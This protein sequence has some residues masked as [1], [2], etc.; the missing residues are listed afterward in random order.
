M[1]LQKASLIASIK[2]KT[3]SEALSLCRSDSR[4]EAACFNSIASLKTI[5]EVVLGVSETKRLLAERADLVT[6]SQMIAFLDGLSQGFAFRLS[7]CVE[8]D[9]EESLKEEQSFLP[10]HEAINRGQKVVPL[11]VEGLL[12]ERDQTEILIVT[13]AVQ[14]I[15]LHME[16]N[17]WDFPNNEILYFAF[18]KQSG[19]AFDNG[20]LYRQIAIKIAA[21]IKSNKGTIETSNFDHDRDFGAEFQEGGLIDALS[22]ILAGSE[23]EDGKFYLPGIEIETELEILRFVTFYSTYNY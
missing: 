6:T 3:L 22:N 4:V 18:W 5:M 19:K 16:V 17:H 11:L 10:Y 8:D 2:G 1:K 15:K 7:L 20:N 9:E 23:L 14:D 12:P 13:I 21:L